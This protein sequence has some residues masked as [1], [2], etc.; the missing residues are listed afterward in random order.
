MNNF[1]ESDKFRVRG[2]IKN[3]KIGGKK[4]VSSNIK[5]M[6]LTKLIPAVGL[7]LL[8]FFSFALLSDFLRKPNIDKLNTDYK[9]VTSIPVLEYSYEKQLISKPLEIRDSENPINGTM[10]TKT[11]YDELLT[12]H[13]VA[14]TIN[15]YPAARSQHGLTYAD[16]VGEF[17]AEGGITRYVPIYYSN[18]EVEKVGPIRSL[19]YYMIMFTSEYADAIILHEGQAGYD[20]APWETYRE[21]AD[22]RGAIRKFGIKNIQTAATRYR[23]PAKVR[24]AGSVHAMYTGFKLINPEVERLGKTNKWQLGSSKL[25][26][27]S[28]KYDDDFVDRGDFSKLTIDFMTLKANGSNFQAEFAYDKQSNSYKRYIAGKEDIDLQSGMQISPKNVVV[29]WHN[30]GDANDGHG[31]IIIDMI[32]KDRVQIFRDGKVIEGYW[33]KDCR[34][35]R[36]KYFDENENPIELNRGQTWIA[37]AVKVKDRLVSNVNLQYNED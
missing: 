35:C 5:S 10:I 17:L 3:H 9:L 32:G 22:A 12:R 28:F 37:F 1:E 4:T 31:R 7:F 27:L 18:Q 21:Q 29:E 33:Q 36:T 20:D 2:T 11:Q 15:N 26:P 8:V 13:P 34:T 24:T 14:I 25:E 23:D 16:V 6:L 19:R 30:Y